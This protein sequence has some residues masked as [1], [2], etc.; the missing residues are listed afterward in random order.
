MP[1]I[2][3]IVKGSGGG[4]PSTVLG[5]TIEQAYGTVTNGVFNRPSGSNL[6]DFTGLTGI[7]D[8]AFYGQYR[9]HKGLS[10]GVIGASTITSI[11]EAAFMTF[12]KDSSFSGTVDFSGVT[13]VSTDSFQDAFDYT[14][15]TSVDFGSL[16]EI[17]YVDYNNQR[18]SVFYG[19]FQTC[20]Y[21]TSINFSK[22]RVVQSGNCFYYAFSGH[23]CIN[24]RFD[25]LDTID[26]T[27]AGYPFA[28]AFGSTYGDT[29]QRHIYFPALRYLL[30]SG[31]SHFTSFEPGTNVTVHFPSNMQTTI[32]AKGWTQ[33]GFV[34]VYD[35]PAVVTLTGANSVDYVRNPKDDTQSALAW[36]ILDNSALVDWTPYYT[37]GTT[38]PV[39]GDTIYSDSSCTT[40]LTTIDSIA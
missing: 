37:S 21:L 32:E 22:L 28:G 39:V 34:K 23:N 15:I 8:Y 29:T 2:N 11:G 20:R 9:E 30:G 3:Q 31:N 24:V 7:G 10:G 14:G 5:L 12:C 17:K 6:P 27:S 33:S 40:A 38:D 26:I 1:I 13:N 25:S 18:L 16:E 19:A 4:T 35:L 36:R